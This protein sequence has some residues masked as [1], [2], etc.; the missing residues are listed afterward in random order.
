MDS[1]HWSV[2]VA[3]LPFSDGKIPRYLL[4][5]RPD[6][7]AS[8]A[9]KPKRP[10]EKKEREKSLN[11]SKVLSQTN[12]REARRS[13]RWSWAGLGWEEKSNVIG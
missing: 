4:D 5:T 3:F 7:L 2:V 13:G 10:Q 12:P 8:V 1:G 9:A 11:S 6:K